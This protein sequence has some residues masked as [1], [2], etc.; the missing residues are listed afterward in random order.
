MN[1]SLRQD[2]LAGETAWREIDLSA[3][4]SNYR[5]VR[6]AI[7]PETKILACL[8]QDAYGCGA[9]Q[10]AAVLV[11]EGVDAFG[12][13]SIRDALAVR[14]AAPAAQILMYAG[15]G[16]D[17]AHFVRDLDL[18]ITLSGEDDLRGWL[19]TGLR[20]KAFVKVDL[21]FWR[22]GVAPSGLEPL[23]DLCAAEPAIAIDSIYAHLSEFGDAG[24]SASEQVARL[25]PILGRL[26]ANGRLPAS[27]M[28][29]SSDSMIRHP[30]FDFDAVDPGALLFGVA[31]AK[32]DG[33]FLTTRPALSAIKTRII[34][35]KQSDDSM[36]TPPRLPGYHHAM[37]L[38]VLG[39]GW[40]QGVPRHLAP[41]ATGLVRGRRAPIVPPPHL[42]HL[43][44]DV[45]DVPDV[46]LGDEVVLLGSSGTD[47]IAL[48]EIAAA[49]NTDEAGVSC[50]LPD[51]LTRF[52]AAS[53]HAQFNQEEG[54]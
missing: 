24:S 16:P 7:R 21:G 44:I 30:E 50:A 6:A 32:P 27:V 36:G 47:Q 18:T 33:R 38:A 12:V 11:A 2:I 23:L 54:E 5:A 41:G 9:G 29:S 3:I 48:P 40:G 39:I 52:Y 19:S 28:I 37:R 49:W 51:T 22:A 26:R 20:L 15:I 4:A 43:R 17:S 10:A 45:T 1:I 8:K 35:L 53:N 25:M 46:R 14:K 42:E 13:V 34:A 31:K